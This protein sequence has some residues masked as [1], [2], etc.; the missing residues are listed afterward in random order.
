MKLLLLALVVAVAACTKEEP[1]VTKVQTPVVVAAPEPVKEVKKCTSP[2]FKVGQVVLTVIDEYK[3][4]VDK[5][6]EDVDEEDGVTG[7][8]W[9]AVIVGFE[10]TYDRTTVD[11]KEIELK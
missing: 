9:Y 1:V 4:I 2:K 8:C 7:V 5:V 10:G 6:Y 3:G 11:Y